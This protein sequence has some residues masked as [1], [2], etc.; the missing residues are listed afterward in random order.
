MKI[1]KLIGY[2]LDTNSM[3]DN[4]NVV[5]QP[6]RLFYSTIDDS[7]Y[8]D[9]GA[10]V[11]SLI[12]INKY[13]KQIGQYQQIRPILSGVLIAEI[14]ANY[15][16]WGSLTAEKK[17]IAVKWILAPYSLRMTVIGDSD[18]LDNFQEL[19]EGTSGVIM[20]KL[21]GRTRVIEEMRQFIGLNYFR[22]DIIS[23]NDIDSFYNDVS[24]LT[25][26]YINSNDP[27][28][29]YWL[30]G[31]NEY[32]GIGL[33]SKTYFDQNMLDTLNKIYSGFY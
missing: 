33:S 4:S 11:N 32:A 15:A 12:N 20:Q 14:G 24:P 19:L 8:E 30:N 25:V 17:Q 28:F 5:K 26:R 9:F 31:L 3:D 29:Y 23:K 10:D 6:F 21:I 7:D 22:K 1:G 27:H 18:D 13:W 16:G 2:N